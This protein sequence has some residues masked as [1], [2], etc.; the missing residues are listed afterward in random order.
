MMRPPASPQTEPP[1]T[2]HPPSP[3]APNPPSDPPLPIPPTSHPPSPIAPNLPPLLSPPLPPPQPGPSSPPPLSQSG[4]PTRM[5]R[6]PARYQDTYPEPPCPTASSCSDPSYPET[7]VRVVPRITLIVRNPFRT[8][9]NS[10]G[11][12]KEYMYRPSWDPDASISAEDL[13]R[14][15]ISATVPEVTIDETPDNEALESGYSNKSVE[16]LMYWKTTGSTQKTDME[17]N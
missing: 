14:P 7:A 13:Y 5:H 8:A 4:R 15:H 17:I 6:L 16:L 1:P 9:S 10:F 2:S 3:I 11:L 12:W